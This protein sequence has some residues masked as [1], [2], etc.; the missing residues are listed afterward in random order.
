MQAQTAASPASHRPHWSTLRLTERGHIKRVLIYKHGDLT[1]AAENLSVS[2]PR[3]S[4]AL[5]GREQIIS[6][7]SAIQHDLNLTD[8][9]VLSFWPLLKSW[10]RISRVN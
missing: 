2:Y 6:V 7:V 4:G 1:R 9:Q 10:P 5:C 8:E 3:L